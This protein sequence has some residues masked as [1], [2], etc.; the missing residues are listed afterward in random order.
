MMKDTKA[1]AVSLMLLMNRI[2]LG[3]LFVLAGVR[4]LLPNAEASVLDKMNGFASFVASKA[5]LPDFL[6]KTYGYA[7]PWAELLFGA[8]L[9]IGLLTRWSAVLVGLMLLSFLI[10]LGPDWWPETGPAYSTNFILLTLSG[11]L[12]VIGSGKFAVKPD[13][14]LK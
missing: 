12:A 7:L 4:K 10:A 3:L 5:P 6:G 11:L 9:I 13:G 2:S 8:M 1:A 14:L